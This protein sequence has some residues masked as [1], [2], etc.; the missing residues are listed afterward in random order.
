MKHLDSGL[1]LGPVKHVLLRC[2]D[3][4]CP[5]L[6]YLLTLVSTSVQD[7]SILD[8]SSPDMAKDEVEEMLEERAGSV[9]PLEPGRL[10]VALRSI[11]LHY[12]GNTL[13]ISSGSLD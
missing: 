7:S 12:G 10:W 6:R 11:N 8:S 5:D 4:R 1:G 9:G 3:Y 13:I 2:P